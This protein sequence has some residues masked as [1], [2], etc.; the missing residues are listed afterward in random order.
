MAEL[1]ASGI[2]RLPSPSP[3]ALSEVMNEF[4][5]FL[6]LPERP[7]PQLPLPAE[8]VPAEQPIVQRPKRSYGIL[9][10]ERPQLSAFLISLMPEEQREEALQGLSRGR[11]VVA[12]MLQ[13][14]KN[15]P[16]AETLAGRLKELY[17]GKLF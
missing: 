11:E 12:E 8:V 17:A 6:A 13:A 2:N 10:Y 1:I 7:R 16:L 4:Q 9:M 14:L 5:S 15:N 3:V